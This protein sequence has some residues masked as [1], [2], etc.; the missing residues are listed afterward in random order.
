VRPL[1]VR[2]PEEHRDLG[3]IPGSILL[4]VD[5]VA[6]APATIPREGKPLLVYCEHGI[7]SA[8]AAA[9]LAR[10][11]FAGILNL[12]GGMSR[13]TGPREHGEGSPFGDH[14]PS[15]WLV[16]NADLLPGG[17]SALDIACGSGRHSLLLASAGFRVRAVDRDPARVASLQNLA[18]RLGLPIDGEVVD[19]ET[20]DADLGR[21]A[22]ELIVGFHYLHRPLFPAILRAL[23]PGGIL[24]YETFTVDQARRGRPTDPD[25]LLRP[26]ELRS[27]TSPLEILREREGEAEGRCVAGIAARRPA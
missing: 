19:L 4:P 25:F 20:G 7:R 27:L 8:T 5:L 23:A 26:G 15:S 9:F 6:C 17:G 18:K 1:D 12:A 13:W 22:F 16:G 24:I 3:H 21:D 2:S 14:G 11:G 10:S